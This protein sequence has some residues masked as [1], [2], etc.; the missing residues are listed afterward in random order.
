M[1]NPNNSETNFVKAYKELRQLP[2]TLS[3]INLIEFILSYTTNGQDF[4]A[5]DKIISDYL[6][7]AEQSS[8]NMVNKL[9]KIGYLLTDTTSNQGKGYGGKTRHIK[10]NLNYINEVL[11]CSS[12]PNDVAAP[13]TENKIQVE[14]ILTDEPI[15]FGDDEPIIFGDYDGSNDTLPASL[16]EGEP[17]KV[18]EYLPT[19]LPVNEFILSLNEDTVINTEPQDMYQV[20]GIEKENDTPTT[21]E[22]C[23]VKALKY[24]QGHEMLSGEITK[25]KNDDM[26]GFLRFAYNKAM[27]SE[28]EKT[29]YKGQNVLELAS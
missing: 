13:L 17:K 1:F 26:D 20:L 10:I 22:Y 4:W 5:S 27:E 29:I 9:T 7:M 16:F 6:K 28:K 15:I 12:K 25:Y 8:K 19:P 2:L 14:T 23:P 11:N 21:L 18:V 3:E 24:A